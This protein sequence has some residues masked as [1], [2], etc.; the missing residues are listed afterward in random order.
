MTDRARDLPTRVLVLS[1]SFS[2]GLCDATM[3]D[4]QIGLLRTQFFFP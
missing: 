2:L 3:Y 4:D 1:C